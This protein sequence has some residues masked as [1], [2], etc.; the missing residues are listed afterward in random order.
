MNNVLFMNIYQKEINKI[1]EVLKKNGMSNIG[2]I[3]T[4][5]LKDIPSILKE[6]KISVIFYKIKNKSYLK[7]L[8]YLKIISHDIPKIVYGKRLNKS[9]FLDVVNVGSIFY[10]L[11][12]PFDEYKLTT[13]LD[14]A[15]SFNK[16]V[17]DKYNRLSKRYFESQIEELNKIGIALSSEHDLKALLNQIVSQAR[18]LAHCDAGSLYIKEGSMLN[19]VVAQNDTLRNRYGDGCEE[20]LFKKFSFPI[21]KERVSGYVAV[22]GH[23]L[24]IK[25]VYNIAPDEEYT[26]TSDFDKRNN[27]LTKSVILSAMK[28]PDHNILGVLQLIN[29]LD[30]DGNI[31][32]FDKNLES[33]IESLA[34]QAAVTIRNAR[35]LQKVKEGH[36]DTILRLSV[37]AEFRDDDTAAHLKRMTTYSLIV[38]KNLG[39]SDLEVELL[40]YS[41][42]MHD[43]GKIGTPDSILL[44]PGKLSKDEWEEMKKHTVYGAQILEGSDSEILKASRIVALNHHERWN[45]RGYPQELKGDNIPIF[46]QIVSV[47]D[48]FDAL[49]SKRCYK[50]AYSLDHALSIIKKSKGDQFGPHIV[51]AFFKGLDEI[52]D[53][54][55]KSHKI[56]NEK[57]K[58]L[59]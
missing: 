41:A 50:E 27:Y 11:E 49:T 55:N 37:A 48:V 42:P 28:D 46:G 17:L 56:K 10:F 26:F 8:D 52:V 45:G 25:D 19:F 35:L 38:A 2:F 53:F 5:S 24:N 31:V 29:R 13:S 12:R 16:R 7:D 54:F 59:S 15:I 36:L 57:V 39:L 1:K 51:D 4:S 44:K 9:N 3:E 21:T 34:S 14:N 33:L 43:I 32:P 47:G 22:T 6:K 58:F 18:F 20:K 40:R 30:E 23:T